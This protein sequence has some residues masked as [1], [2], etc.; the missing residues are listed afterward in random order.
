MW[1]SFSINHRPPDRIVFNNLC[2]HT[3]LGASL[4][5]RPD[6]EQRKQPVFI[7]ISVPLSLKSAG[8]D[9]T[10]DDSVSYGTMCK[11]AEKIAKQE[12]GFGSAEGLA[13]GLAEG[14]LAAFGSLSEVNVRVNK[15]RALL[16]CTSAGVDITRSRFPGDDGG[17]EDVYFLEGLA[18]STIIG[19]NPWERVEKQM[20]HLD[21]SLCKT[22]E[23][24]E[25]NALEFDF[26]ALA[27]RVSDHVLQS[28]YQ[29]V[30]SMATAIAKISLS[31]DE[32]A[33][34]VTVKVAKPSA[35]MFAAAAEVEI[36]RT[37][38]DFAISPVN[39]SELGESGRKH[40]AVI[41]LGSNLGDRVAN[42]ERS[43]KLLEAAGV[44]VVETSFMYETA[45]MYVEDQPMFLNAACVVETILDA[46]NLMQL[47][48][49]VE[50]DAGRTK[51]FRNGPRVVDLDIIFSD[52]LHTQIKA[53]DNNGY[54]LIVPHMRV[55]EREFVLRPL[56]DIVPNLVHPVLGKSVTSLLRSVT[57]GASPMYRILPFPASPVSSAFT[58]P[59][60]RRTYIMTI[61]N[62]TPDSFSDGGTHFVSSTAAT[63]EQQLENTIRSLH[64]A[65]EDGADIL[66][67]GGYSTRPGAADVSEEEEIARVVPL[68]KA[69]RE[70][71]AH[72]PISVDTFRASVARAAVA[73]GASCINDV[74][75]LSRDPD[76]LQ[77]AYDLA[78][79]VVM[80]HSRGD[81]GQEKDYSSYDKVM[82]GV[83]AELGEKVARALRAGVRR[84]NIVADP[85]VGFSKTVDG[86]LA[87]LRELPTLTAT[88][89]G[90]GRA[91][92]PLDHLPVLVGTSRKGF[93]GVITG[94]DKAQER[95]M[96]TAVTCAAA[97]QGGADIIRV[98]DTRE[99]RD[100]AK[101]ADALWRSNS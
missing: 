74:Y 47:V 33:R 73:A 65:V 24:K 62:S 51:T 44:K 64:R 37:P 27:S 23:H 2:V 95:I 84:W 4:W 29:T 70:T 22:P 28:S 7:S 99:M 34:A 57:T 98:H 8:S 35:L 71:D 19:I 60:S 85:G 92:H 69:F 5:P 12:R 10:L 30:E 81:A 87:V 100:V 18:L 77:A 80:M 15:P 50:E 59:L 78:V 63:Y 32:D 61:V 11:L 41:A 58:W 89:G 68:I 76:M 3:T 42:I 31:C 91:R 90:A 67:I 101:V 25:S 26:R 17:K 82:D 55:Q 40:R 96:P 21:I 72:T 97:V 1:R 14:C 9:D 56:A 53:S 83:R 54:E 75:A 38:A 79:P 43:L 36:T 20:V 49:R 94:T 88:V 6:A 39:L 93:L 66:D 13:E 52:S 45:A 48:K 46:G 86:N 16:H